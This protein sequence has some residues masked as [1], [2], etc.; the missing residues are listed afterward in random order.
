MRLLPRQRDRLP[1]A[2]R[3]LYIKADLCV[4]HEPLHMTNPSPAPDGQVADAEARNWVDTY[5][6]EAA[7]PYLRLSRLDRPTPILFL[8]LPCWWGL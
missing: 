8:L 4:T 1:L 2:Q 3:V 6:P 7:R 5:A